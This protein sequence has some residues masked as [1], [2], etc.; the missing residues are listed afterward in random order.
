MVCPLLILYKTVYLCPALNDQ[1]IFYFLE[2]QEQD[3]TF[4]L[5]FRHHDY[6]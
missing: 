6:V 3:I 5:V 4:G 2:F 1:V